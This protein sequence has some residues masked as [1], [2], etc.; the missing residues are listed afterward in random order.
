MH[1]SQ[2]FLLIKYSKDIFK[3]VFDMPDI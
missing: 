1:F 2:T 3:V